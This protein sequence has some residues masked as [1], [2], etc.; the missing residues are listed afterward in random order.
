MQSMTT[1]SGEVSVPLNSETT[2]MHHSNRQFQHSKELQNHLHEAIKLAADAKPVSSENTAKRMNIGHSTSYFVSQ[3][4]AQ[5]AAQMQNNLSSEQSNNASSPMND[6]LYQQQDFSQVYSTHISQP[7]QIQHGLQQPPPLQM[8]TIHQGPQQLQQEQ[9]NNQQIYHIQQ[10][11]LQQHT[12]QFSQNAAVIPPTLSNA[13]PFP[14]LSSQPSHVANTST[15]SPLYCQ[16]AAT[17]SAPVPIVKAQAK[18]SKQICK[19]QGCDQVAASRRPYCTKH[20]GNRLCEHQG[21]TKCAQGATR[22]CIGH[23]GGRR[24]TYP[25]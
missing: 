7:Q 3:N 23:G 4:Q 8:A 6:L 1:P 19:I 18:G 20:S 14:P 13:P 21:C 9:M 12:Q 22:F 5:H 16:V 10:S 24:C 17:T 15:T 2:Q 25:G 11:Q